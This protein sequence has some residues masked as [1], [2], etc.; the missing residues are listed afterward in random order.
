MAERDVGAIVQG[1]REKDH[2]VQL[3]ARGAGGAAVP[4]L[5][6]LLQDPDDEVRQLAVHCLAET[7]DPR[8]ADGIA[9]A[10]LDPEPEV[11]LAAA[12]A[13]HRLATPPLAPGLLDALGRARDPL[14]RREIALVLGRV[15]G[16]DAA[17][18]LRDRLGREQAP[19]AAEGL[20]VALARLGDQEAQ[21][22]FEQRLL[23]A[24]G[25]E[26][27]TWLEHAEYVARPWLVRPLEKLLG[28]TTPVL[29]VG[30][31]AR[32]DLIEALRVCDLALILI[33]ALSGARFSFPVT[34]AK[35]YSAAE[36]DE[37]R[38][39]VKSLP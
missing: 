12:R 6:P 20:L 11:A 38:R 28:D 36:I 34:R 9:Q 10:L 27:R 37:A 22:A 33:A 1:V 24:R 14:V 26:R 5:V 35:N 18:A 3:A 32:P 16:P 29:R 30:V 31:D 7:G 13:L 39:L 15:A 25:L 8:A 2:A 19:E 17:G 4:A 23:A 21:R